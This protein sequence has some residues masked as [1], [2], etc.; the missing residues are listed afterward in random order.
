MR[1]RLGQNF[2]VDLEWQRKIVGYFETSKFFGEIGPGR[3]ALTQWL[4]QEHPN[5]IVFEK[6]EELVEYHRKVGGYDVVAGDF[7]DWDFK[8]NG[9]AVQDFA[10]IGNLPYE[11]GTAMIQRIVEHADQI[12]SFVFLLQKEVVERLAARPKTKAFGSLTVHVQGQ[13]DLEALDIIPPS[14]FMP[15]PQVHSQIIRGKRRS[16]PHHI[17]KDFSR[18]VQAAFSQKRKTLRNSLL[19]S[20]NKD[21]IDSV[22]SKFN[23]SPTIRAEEIAVDL[24]PAIFEEVKRG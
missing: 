4:K 18:F 23:F 12:P 13:Y 9:N 20:V 5:F 1:A 21:K 15:R 11:V 7:L 3:G 16:S 14:A 2:L 8:V 10:L 24:W 22:I 19:S 6:D 17:S